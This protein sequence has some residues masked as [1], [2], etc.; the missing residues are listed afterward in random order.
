MR[1]IP[2]PAFLACCLPAFLCRA[3]EPPAPSEPVAHFGTTVV[4][5]SGLRGEIYYIPAGSRRLPNFKKLEPVGVIYTNTLDIPPVQFT[6]GFPGV[7]GRFEWFAID[8]TGR[9]WIETAGKYRF[10]LLS[11]DGSRL[12]ID[13]RGVINNDGVH[14]PMTRQ[15]EIALSRGLHRIRVAYFQGPRFHVALV[16]RVAAPGEDWQVFNMDRFCPPAELEK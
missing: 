8:Y 4:I 16:L 14:P 11:D 12:Y 9:V 15:G 3:Q 13:G 2:K 10:S 7:T 1:A 5:S 6:E